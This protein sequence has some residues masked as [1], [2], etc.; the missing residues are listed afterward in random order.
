MNNS[1]IRVRISVTFI[2]LIVTF[3]AIVILLNYNNS[4]KNSYELS[5]KIINQ[6]AKSIIEKTKFY[7]SKSNTSLKILGNNNKTYNIYDIEG[8]NKEVMWE[9]LL[10][11]EHIAS[12]FL[13][14]RNSNFFQVRRDP[15]LAI[16]KIETIDNNRIDFYEYKDKND[17]TL[18]YKSS[19]ASYNP[20][21]RPWYINTNEKKIH[22]SKPY[23]FDSTKKLGITISYGSLDKYGN[24]LAVSAVDI[25]LDTLQEFIH[26]QAKSIKGDIYL[27]D[28]DYNLITS[29]KNKLNNHFLKKESIDKNNFEYFKLKNHYESGDFK[30]IIQ[31]QGENSI[32]EISS[33]ELDSNNKLGVLVTIP[34][35]I[36]L[37]RTKEML[38]ITIVISLLFLSVFVFLSFQ[39]SKMISRPI[40]QFAKDI[41][42]LRDLKTHKELKN[43]SKIKEI[44]QAQRALISLQHG[45][46]AFK[47]YMPSDLVKILVDTNQEAKI[48][49]DEKNLAIMFTD[50][51]GFTTISETMTP[52][53]LT[54][55]LSIYFDEMEKVIS[56]YHGTI[57][58][59]IGDAIMGFWGAP[60]DIDQPIIKA[61]QCALAMQEKLTQLN[62]KWEKEG[63][64]VLKTRIGVHYGKTLVG[65]IG[66]PNRMNYTIIGDTVNVASRLEGINK[67]Y[68]TNIMVSEE[69][70]TMIQDQFTLE[71]ID[72]IE[73]KGKTESTKIYTLKV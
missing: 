35:D 22:I 29:S 55:H 52:S 54:Q 36:V 56:K 31:H 51:E 62:E 15:K 1:P 71:Y 41:K 17:I 61:V 38:M 60:V 58:K 47:K 63:K 3:A 5:D 67:N 28:K 40:A 24:K 21:I 7:L 65:N 46:R 42:D 27:F 53:E 59:Y 12:V 4:L 44:Y 50:I 66:S 10:S 26:E 45:I 57:D 73:L 18:G 43:D 70:Y 72:Q 8:L 39:M 48:G 11:E 14:D 19:L 25:T 9:L 20:I 33:L 68:G 16:R 49:G 2:S 69:V 13:A 32:Y 64:A 34:E 23:I 37:G 6:T 30:G